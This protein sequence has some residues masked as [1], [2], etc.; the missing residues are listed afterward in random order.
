MLRLTVTSQVR[1]PRKIENF[2]FPEDG[3]SNDHCC[4]G[5][6]YPGGV[7]LRMNCVVCVAA[8]N[9]LPAE[10]ALEC[11]V[12]AELHSEE[13]RTAWPV[14]SGEVTFAPFGGQQTCLAHPSRRHV[15]VTPQREG[16]FRCFSR[17]RSR[18]QRGTRLL[19]TWQ[20]SPRG[21]FSVGSSTTAASDQRPAAPG[22][23]QRPAGRC[24][25][26]CSSSRSCCRSG[27]RT[28]RS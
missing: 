19:V 25:R 7:A 17:A 21:V 28:D 16:T 3:S 24:R 14:D 11:L 2:R 20:P 26:T 10:C 18:Q 8:A 4:T 22:R 9:I 23:R 5:P 6:S 15:C 1:T 27:I 12:P 13:P